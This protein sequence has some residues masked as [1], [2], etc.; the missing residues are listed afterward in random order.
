MDI[1]EGRN[2]H[3]EGSQHS[4]TE[5]LTPCARQHLKRD[6]QTSDP[7]CNSEFKPTHALPYNV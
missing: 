3:D 2:A 7:H 5:R 6:D 4:Y 1:R